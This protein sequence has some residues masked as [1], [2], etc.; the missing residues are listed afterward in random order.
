[1]RNEHVLL[2]IA[3]AEIELDTFLNETVSASKL[4]IDVRYRVDVDIR[5]YTEKARL[6]V[7]PTTELVSPPFFQPSRSHSPY[8]AALE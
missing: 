3:S 5:L 7:Y 6:Y 1:M 2:K 4:V 8:A